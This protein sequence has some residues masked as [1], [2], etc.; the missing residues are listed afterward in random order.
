MLQQ[1]EGGRLDKAMIKQ[2][3]KFKLCKTEDIY[4]LKMQ[5]KTVICLF[6]II[7]EKDSI[8]AG[9]LSKLY[10]KVKKLETKLIHNFRRDPLFGIGFFY[11]IDR[12]RQWQS[13]TWIST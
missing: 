11:Q 8:V 9:Q 10:S 12:C 1:S 4:K 7:L 5:L 3:S 2:L 6:A 13:K